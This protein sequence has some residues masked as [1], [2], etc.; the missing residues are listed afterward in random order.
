M[1]KNFIIIFLFFLLSSLLIQK[2][3]NAEL[4]IKDLATSK[5]MVVE[6]AEYV[7][8]TFSKEFSV[9]EEEKE[10]IKETLKE[11]VDL[12]KRKPFAIHI[13]NIS[14]AI[15]NRTFFVKLRN[16]IPVGIVLS[17][18]LSI[19]MP[20]LSTNIASTLSNKFDGID[21]LIS[22]VLPCLPLEITLALI[23]PNISISANISEILL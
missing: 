7:K 2:P 18:Y 23:N 11:K 13:F 15:F 16:Y 14:L 20:R 17:I 10:S 9:I 6:G 1:F 19:Y 4:L 22:L 12:S 5:E 8:K 3:D 21:N